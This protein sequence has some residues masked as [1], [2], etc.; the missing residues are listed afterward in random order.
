MYGIYIIHLSLVPDIVGRYLG[1]IR[2]GSIFNRCET[3]EMAREV[4]VSMTLVQIQ[5]SSPLII[6]GSEV[7]VAISQFHVFITL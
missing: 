3:V 1:I 6:R 5:V 2:H 7:T 4:R